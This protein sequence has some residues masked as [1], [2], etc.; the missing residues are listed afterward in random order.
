MLLNWFRRVSQ[1]ECQASFCL[2]LPIHMGFPHYARLA[3]KNM[4]DLT[5]EAI[6]RLLQAGL[7]SDL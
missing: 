3:T 2:D 6:D 5:L 1:S 7:G 4:E